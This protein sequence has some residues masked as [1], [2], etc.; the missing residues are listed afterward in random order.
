MK[1]D[2]TKLLGEDAKGKDKCKESVGKMGESLTRSFGIDMKNPTA[3]NNEDTGYQKAGQFVSEVCTTFTDPTNIMSIAPFAH[4]YLGSEVFDAAIKTVIER[5][6]KHPNEQQFL[7]EILT[8]ATLISPEKRLQFLGA[9]RNA[10]DIADEM[11]GLGMLLANSDPNVRFTTPDELPV[12]FR[13]K[14]TVKSTTLLGRFIELGLFQ[15]G[16]GFTKEFDSIVKKMKG[17]DYMAEDTSLEHAI[18]IG[19]NPVFAENE[20]NLNIEQ[21]NQ[22]DA[23]PNNTGANPGIVFLSTPV[24]PVNVK[25]L[26]PQST[27]I[28]VAKDD[29]DRKAMQKTLGADADWALDTAK[30]GERA[31]RAYV[32][33]VREGR[34]NGLV[35]L[36]DI[37]NAKL[38]ETRALALAGNEHV[39]DLIDEFE[40][41]GQTTLMNKFIQEQGLKLPKRTN[42]KLI[43]LISESIKD[44]NLYFNDYTTGKTAYH[45]NSLPDMEKTGMP[46]IIVTN[47]PL[48]E[49][50]IHAKFPSATVLYLARNDREESAIRNA[51]GA[52]SFVL[53]AEYMEK[54]VGY[55]KVGDAIVQMLFSPIAESRPKGIVNMADIVKGISQKVKTARDNIVFS[56]GLRDYFQ[57]ASQYWNLQEKYKGS[58]IIAQQADGVLMKTCPTGGCLK[59]TDRPRESCCS[60]NATRVLLD[61][62]IDYRKQVGE[63][64]FAVELERFHKGR[65]ATPWYS[66][67]YQYT[68]V[69]PEIKAGKKRTKHNMTF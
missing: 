44:L 54:K 59:M 45:Y 28:Y 53:N 1:G 4:A 48:A 38:E 2:L 16:T 8:G 60:S 3:P 21:T 5:A 15:P 35:N 32:N 31:L 65:Q 19:K 56:E 51:N 41:L 14:G 17:L 18:L 66:T 57:A 46:F 11:F 58:P 20:F 33:F 34:S 63:E 36:E 22:Y 47:K 68:E 43:M 13:D 55:G 62:A 23:R 24:S 6:K 27:L 29:K 30:Y 49:K 69:F 50:E 7:D 39:F 9:V 25:K 61:F 67:E 64:D 12:Q 37:A 26:Y 10:G 52:E 42:N 40:K